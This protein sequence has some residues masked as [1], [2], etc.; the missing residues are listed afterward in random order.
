M[1]HQTAKRFECLPYLATVA[2][3]FARVL[4]ERIMVSQ[5]RL[6]PSRA[7]NGPHRRRRERSR[8]NPS[9]TAPLRGMLPRRASPEPKMDA[10]NV[11]VFMNG[12]PRTGG[13]LDVS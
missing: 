9:V 8:A 3:N 5:G 13:G 12:V 2:S 11:V 10:T 4:P 6:R 1:P 7:P